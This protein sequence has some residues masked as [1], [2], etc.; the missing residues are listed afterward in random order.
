MNKQKRDRTIFLICTYGCEL[1]KGYKSY[2]LKS[3]QQAIELDV[4]EILLVGGMTNQKTNPSQSEAFVAMDFFYGLNG[5]YGEFFRSVTL[6]PSHKGNSFREVAEIIHDMYTANLPRIYYYC[7]PSHA[8]KN[9]M[10]LSMNG[11]RG[12][13]WYYGELM[14][15]P[16]FEFLKQN[17]LALPLEF[18]AYFSSFVYRL[19]LKWREDKISRS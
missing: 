17:F 5:K 14:V 16:T 11:F 19:Q 10:H 8:F 1:T 13:C 7:Q 12:R 3:L 2:L 4:H 15:L 6:T 9:M 18:I